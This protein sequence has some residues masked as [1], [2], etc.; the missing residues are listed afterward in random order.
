MTPAV[1]ALQHPKIRE[2]C[3][4]KETQLE[5][6]HRWGS[7]RWRKEGLDAREQWVPRSDTGVC[8]CECNATDPAQP[9]DSAMGPTGFVPS[10]P[11]ALCNANTLAKS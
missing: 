4:R 10:C 7:S 2:K 3:G 8:C 9:L 5:H 1:N 11:A 6:F